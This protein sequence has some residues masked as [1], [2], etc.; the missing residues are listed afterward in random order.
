MENYPLTRE[1]AHT[2]RNRR[3]PTLLP[4]RTTRS[5]A[6]FSD[7]SENTSGSTLKGG[8]RPAVSGR[9]EYSL[10]DQAGRMVR[11]S[12]VVLKLTRKCEEFRTDSEADKS[13][14]LKTLRYFCLQMLRHSIE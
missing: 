9:T 12:Y 2:R 6:A 14:F 13:N 3:G 11:G 5:L 8:D 10:I 4:E 1:E 7:Q